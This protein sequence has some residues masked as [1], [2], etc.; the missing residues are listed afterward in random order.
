MLWKRSHRKPCIFPIHAFIAIEYCV[1]IKTDIHLKSHF[2]ES[3]NKAQGAMVVFK[4]LESGVSFIFEDFVQVGLQFFYFEKFLMIGSPFMYVNATFMVLKAAEFAIRV[5]MV[6]RKW[7][8]YQECFVCLTKS[9]WIRKKTK[10]LRIYVLMLLLF[11]AS[12]SSSTFIHSVELREHFIN[13]H[14]EMLSSR[15]ANEII[16]K[17][18]N[19]F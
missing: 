15:S 13:Y 5:L 3:Y 9:S 4:F 19:T 2:K 18:L 14:V 10:L 8:N 17:C 1:S 16:W 12:L 7:W 11:F 6:W